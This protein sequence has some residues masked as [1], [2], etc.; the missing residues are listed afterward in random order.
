ML[1]I[2]ILVS[3][4]PFIGIYLWLRNGVSK[5]DAH[6]KLCDKAL[7]QGFLTTFP[8]VLLSLIFNI[9][10]ILTGVKTANPLLYQALY[11]FIILALSEESAKLWMTT[12]FMKKHEYPYSW[13]DVTILFTI[14]GIGF[15]IL[16]SVIYSFGASIPVVLVRGICVP[17]VSYGFLVGY[18]YGKGLKT[19]NKMT[20]WT[21]F[22]I[23]WLIH[24]LYDFS[25]SEEFLAINENIVFVPLLI[26]LSDVVLAVVLIVFTLKARKSEK[27]T[28]YI[29]E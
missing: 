6:R 20:R 28:E 5:E 22:V 15:G 19:G 29:K 25:L 27:Y 23:A 2:A 7:I 18:F 21:G 13:L 4:I 24:G 26:A 8:V 12:R 17:H 10:I 16:E 9:L 11:N 3:F 14:V 1:M